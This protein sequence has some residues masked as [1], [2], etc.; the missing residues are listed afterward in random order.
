ML[1]V[2][3]ALVEWA[4]RGIP[5]GTG[6]RVRAAYYSRRFGRFGRNVRIDEWVV[7]HNPQNMEVGDDVWIMSGAVLTAPSGEEAHLA[8]NKS[9]VHGAGGAAH[10]LRV[11]NEVQV[12]HYNIINGIGGLTIGDCVTLS[13]NVS[14]YSATHLDR[15]PS[16]PSIR[17]GANGMVH[18]RPV[19]SKHSFVLIGDGA[20]LGLGVNVI[21]A[22]VGED[23][24]VVSGSTVTQDVPNNVVVAGQPAVHKRTRFAE[25]VQRS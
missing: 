25:P 15:D 6:Q 19:F 11:G 9:I 3:N 21:C 16:D 2:L 20:W 4:I 1:T 18:S 10:K 22:C 7:F 5:G 14:I 24:F 23:A 12:G 17:V 13:A 8:A